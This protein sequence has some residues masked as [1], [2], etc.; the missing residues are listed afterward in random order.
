MTVYKAAKCVIA[1][2]NLVGADIAHIATI[3]Y[4][5]KTKSM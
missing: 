1:L 5:Y 4:T 3:L 2:C